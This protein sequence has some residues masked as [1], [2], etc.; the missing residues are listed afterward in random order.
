MTV[1]KSPPH[2]IALSVLTGFLGS[3]KTTLLNRVLKD[4]VFS[5]TVVIINEFGDVG[6]DH[7][8]ME[9][10]TEQMIELSSGCLCCTIRGDLCDTL[11]KLLRDRD[12]DRIKKFDRVIIETTGLADPAPILQTLIGH[13]YFLKRFRLNAVV[14]T[15]DAVHGCDTLDRHPEAIKQAAL[16]DILVLTKT[17]TPDWREE[18]GRVLEERLRALNPTAKRLNADEPDMQHIFL[19]DNTYQPDME[20]PDIHKWLREEHQDTHDHQHDHHHHDH[21]HHHDVNRHDDNIRSFSFIYDGAIPA[22]QYDLFLELVRSNFG[23]KLLRYKGIV[24]IKEHEDRPV[25]SHG[26]QH[27]FYPP[28]TLEAWPDENHQTRIVCITDGVDK[29]K[30]E[31]LFKAFA[32]DIKTTY[33]AEVYDGDNPLSL[34]RQ[35]GL[36]K[37]DK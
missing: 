14:T 16:A 29:G 22:Q 2:P 9:A 36:L 11:E 34:D 20:N 35:D 37:G 6:L 23:E 25:I 5:N 21:E 26:V 27:V 4:P 33:H 1:K 32:G 18:K 15:I 10:S 3:G 28:Q 31:G 30:I 13:P 24:K 7:L 17:D 8:L 12:N 19:S